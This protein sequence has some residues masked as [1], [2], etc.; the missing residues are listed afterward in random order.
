MKSLSLR[1]G[2][3]TVLAADERHLDLEAFHMKWQR[4]IGLSTIRRQDHIRN[5]EVAARTGLG[6]VSDLIK[7]RRNSVFGEVRSHCQAFRRYAS[8]PSTP[9]SCWSD[10][11]PSSR[12][13]LEASSR[14]SEQRKDRPAPQGQQWHTTSWPVAK[15]HHASSYRSDARV[16]DDYALTTTTSYWMMSVKFHRHLKEPW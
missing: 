14:S 2:H 16:F 5:S 7:R 4:Q 10:S 11:R 13:Q 6:L 3:W 12:A 9:V 1:H 15:I 8:T